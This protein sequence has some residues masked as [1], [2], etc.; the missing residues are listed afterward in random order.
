MSDADDVDPESAAR[1]ALGDDVGDAGGGMPDAAEGGE[2]GGGDGKGVIDA[3]FETKPAATVDD[4]PGLP[5]W[6]ANALIGTVKFVNGMAGGRDVDTGK[7]AI[8]N[9]AE[10]AVGFA[11]GD[12]EREGGDD[13]S[14]D[15]VIETDAAGPVGQAEGA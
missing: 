10:A 14:D 8:V 3:L 7:P 9:F 5:A 13:S 15:G 6:A 11:L 2:G 4:Y 1:I 12:D